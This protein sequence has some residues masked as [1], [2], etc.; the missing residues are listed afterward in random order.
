MGSSVSD[1]SII[2]GGSGLSDTNISAVSINNTNGID[3]INADFDTS[4]SIVTL[5]LQ[6]PTLGFTTSTYPFVVGQKIFVEGVDIVSDSG[7]GYNSTD[8]GYKS[9]D[10]IIANNVFSI[11][12]HA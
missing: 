10:V 4:T 9:F 5:T 1:V 12:P 2:N 8:H 7:D 11:L 3:V 6:T